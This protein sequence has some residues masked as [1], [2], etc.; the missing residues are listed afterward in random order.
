MAFTPLL[1][2]NLQTNSSRNKIFIRSTKEKNSN[3][4]KDTMMMML[5]RRRQWWRRK[6]KIFDIFVNCNWVDT[7]WE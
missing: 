6:K 7:R 1:R 4:D 2:A 3:R 5:M